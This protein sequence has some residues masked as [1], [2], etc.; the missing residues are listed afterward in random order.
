M[1]AFRLRAEVRALRLLALLL[2][3]AASIELAAQ[4]DA[5]LFTMNFRDASIE[6]VL[7]LVFEATGNTIIPDPRLRNLQVTFLN[8]R[9]MTADELWQAFLQILQSNG[10]AA[11]ESEGIWRIVSDATARSEASQLSGGTGAALATRFVS[12]EN[13]SAATL[14]PT[15]RPLMSTAIGNIAAIPGT[16]TMV[17]TDRADNM[18]RIV[19][20]VR[21]LDADSAQGTEVVALQ[22]AAAQDVSQKLSQLISAQAS[23]GGI[24]GMQAIADERTN[25]IV[26]SGTQS[27]IAR[28]RPLVDALDL[29]ATQGG[30]SEVRYLYY[31]DAEE[32][33]DALQGQF[34]GTQVAESAETATDPT[35]GNINVWADVGTNSLVMRAPSQ[36]LRDM[37][38][39]VDALDIPRAQVH[40]QAIIVEMS[41]SRAAEFGLTWVVGNEEGDSIV[42]LTNFTAT[43]G[44]ILQL[45]AGGED[46]TPD[47]GLIRDGLTAAIGNITDSGTSWAAVISALQ[48]DAQ[49][50]VVQLPNVTVLD[51]TE[52]TIEVGQEVPF[53]TG[54]YAGANAGQGPGG[55]VNPFQTTERSSVGTLLTITPRINEGTGVQMTIEQEVSSISES[56]IASD[57]ITNQRRIVTSVYVDDGNVLVLGGL[58]DDQ[59]RE[60]E[61]KVPWFGNIP[62]LGWLFKARN[63]QLTNTVM[64]VFIRPTIL[65]DSL[66]ASRLT[67]QRY[68]I[69]IDEQTRRSAEP[70]QLMKDAERPTLP[71]LESLQGSP[72]GGGPQTSEAA[73]VP[74]E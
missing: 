45:A 9:A 28:Y 60:G 40:I 12:L 47:P 51:N 55:A 52:A 11:V 68:Q 35:G 53:I 30:G 25:S 54:A 20:I 43:T 44:G 18:A 22:F 41:E 8:Q 69:L 70:V 16:N 33:A 10:Y 14:V 59:L 72:V 5:R 38:A 74:T 19:E 46:G 48:G 15:L 29:P 42:G 7:Q 2:A 58:M 24:V 37:L 39:I 27:Q 50:N 4:D 67:N 6:E 64:M 63:T 61:Q 1:R 17:L 66:A 36:V 65:R 32:L 13:V 73:P 71:P 34:G 23:A 31:A 49:T 3:G 21:V 26:L 56:D 57:V 62:G